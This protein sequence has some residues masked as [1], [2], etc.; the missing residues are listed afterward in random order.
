MD[1]RSERKDQEM[2]DRDAKRQAFE[3]AAD[4]ALSGSINS[5]VDQADGDRV[6]FYQVDLKLVDMESNIEA[7]N[8]QKKLKKLSEK[9]RFGF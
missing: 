8:G 1:L 7:W 6:T 5:I 9:S 3:K 4:Y 2:N